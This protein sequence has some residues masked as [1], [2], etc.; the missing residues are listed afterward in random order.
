M[1]STFLGGSAFDTALSIA[2]DTFND[3]YVSGL[4]FSADFPTTAGA[5]QT[6]P[7]SLRDA[8]VVKIQVTEIPTNQ[9]PDCTTVAASPDSLWPPNHL[10]RLITLGG[11]T[12]PDGD[13]IS[14]VIDGVTQDEPLNSS[15]DGNTSPDAAAAS[16]SDQVYVRAERSGIGDGRVYRISFTASDGRGGTCMGTTTVGVPHDAGFGSVPIDS[17]LVVDSFGF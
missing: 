5:F 2:I 3:V 14:L 12:D 9:P 16:D 8:F 10:L 6:A 13:P 7:G 1:H 17:G 15:S 11:A 4:T